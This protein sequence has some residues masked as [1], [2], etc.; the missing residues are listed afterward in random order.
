M[1]NK[2]RINHLKPIMVTSR[3]QTTITFLQENRVH[4][5]RDLL[6]NNPS[7][8]KTQEVEDISMVVNLWVQIQKLAL[9]IRTKTTIIP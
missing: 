6:K 8:T 3:K 5:D 9:A 1:L 7:R 4:L 2:P